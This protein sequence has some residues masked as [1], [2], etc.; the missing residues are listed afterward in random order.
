[1]YILAKE[2]SRLGGT[3]IED[4]I[5]SIMFQILSNETGQLY[6]REGQKDNRKCK[7]YFL[8]KLV[9]KSVQMNQKTANAIE[10]DIIKPMREWLVRAKCRQLSAVLNQTQ[11]D[12]NL[13][14]INRNLN[15][16]NL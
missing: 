5:K 15:M 3:T 11:E 2:L 1:M 4:V 10:A 14:R 6:S 9:I 12:T 8:T 16:Y 13:L 7:D